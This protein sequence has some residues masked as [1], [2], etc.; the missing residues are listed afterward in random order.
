M[1]TKGSVL[2]NINDMNIDDIMQDLLHS[3]DLYADIFG[4][5]HQRS[6]DIIESYPNVLGLWR[7]MLANTGDEHVQAM[8]VKFFYADNDDAMTVAYRFHD[9]FTQQ[10]LDQIVSDLLDQM[11]HVKVDERILATIVRHGKLSD[12]VQERLLEHVK[13]DEVGSRIQ[14]AM[15]ENTNTSGDSLRQLYDWAKNG[16]EVNIGVLELIASNLSAPGDLLQQLYDWA[17]NGAEVNIWMLKRI[18]SNPSAPSDLLQQL[19]THICSTN[20]EIDFNMFRVLKCIAANSN[21]PRDVAQHLE[22]NSITAW[23]ALNQFKNNG[24][25]QALLDQADVP[26]SFTAPGNDQI[27]TET[28]QELLDRI[29]KNEMRNSEFLSTARHPSASAEVLRQVFKNF[30]KH[31]TAYSIMILGEI[32]GNIHTPAEILQQ[33]FNEAK[34]E[35]MELMKYMT[36]TFVDEELQRSATKIS[37]AI[38]SGL[39]GN[40]QTPI[41]MLQWLIENYSTD[42]AIGWQ[43]M[44]QLTNNPHYTDDAVLATIAAQIIHDPIKLQFFANISSG[45]QLV[46]II[47]SIM[48]KIADKHAGN[49]ADMKAE[50]EQVFSASPGQY[51]IKL[52]SNYS[53]SQVG[54]FLGAC[55]AAC[56]LLQQYPIELPAN[57]VAGTELM[58]HINTWQ[59]QYNNGLR[60]HVWRS[61]R[62]TELAGRVDS[63]ESV[64]ETDK[65]QH[66][67]LRD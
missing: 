61:K 28:T 38:F 29:K 27:F 8:L 35:N 39:A 42:R 19:F 56:P 21:A 12:D 22:Q 49:F 6:A 18:A 58:Q 45:E 65:Q 25:Y 47:G 11:P 1:N 67:G 53:D 10:D 40:A 34:N 24:F 57:Y 46:K 4:K 7:A 36:P 60:A 50:M 62:A 48:Q 20:G 52:C 14:A 43:T 33:L 44:K 3:K 9:K 64:L 30:K 16:A 55:R 54:K 31:D 59:C 66:Y 41:P 51:L 15:A 5:Y 37:R 13:K 32:T 23:P 2:S 17:K 63:V 26:L